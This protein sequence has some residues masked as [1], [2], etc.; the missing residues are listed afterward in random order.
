MSTVRAC[1]GDAMRALRATGVG[2]DPT[3]DELAAGLE[4]ASN[5]I[6]DIHEARGPML[7]VD[8]TANITPGENQRIRVQ[9][10]ATISITLPNSIPVFGTSNPYDYG[11]TAPVALA[12]V[13]STASADG[14]SYRAPVDGARIEIVGTTTALYFYR[15]DINTWQAATGLTV[16]SEIPF[17]ARLTSAFAALLAERLIDVVSDAQPTATLMR[18]IARGRSAM[19]L[20]AGK[21]RAET[22]GQYF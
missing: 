9:A 20:R 18:R 13:G 4:A 19:S 22:I 12:P 17:N 7:G 16:D 15:E 21:A 3:A 6:L 10:A 2:D 5:L 14:V 8:A 1:I 11:F